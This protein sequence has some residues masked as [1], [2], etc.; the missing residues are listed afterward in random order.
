MKPLQT[1]GAKLNASLIISRFT[2]CNKTKTRSNNHHL[3]IWR[4]SKGA[5]GDH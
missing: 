1:H 2:Q 5:I 3:W 4:V